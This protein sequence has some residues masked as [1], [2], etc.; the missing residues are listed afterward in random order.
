MTT[1]TIDSD[2]KH[3]LSP[4][5]WAPV[6]LVVLGI[7]FFYDLLFTSKNLY[8]RDILSFHYPLRSV[9]IDAYSRAQFPLWNPFVYF[10]QPLL[11]NPNAMAF[12]P[13]N[14]FHL[15]LPFEYAF[16]L[17]FIVHPLVAGL[18]A[19]FLQRRLGLFP[20]AAFGGSLVYQFSGTVLSFL[21]LYNIVPGIAILPWLGW[22]YLVAVSGRRRLRRISLFAGILAVQVVAM[23]PLVMQCGLWL[24]IGLSIHHCRES[25][26]RR[27]ALKH[28]GIVLV[29]GVSLA[30]LL[31]AV[32]ILPT[33]ELLGHSSRGMGYDP[34]EI[35]RWSMHPMDF[36]NILLPNF[37]GSPYTLN[38]SIYWGEAFHENREGYLV[39][40]F[41]GSGTL[42]LV[43]LSLWSHRR[44]LTILFSTLS[45]VGILFASG[46][47]NP[48]VTWLYEHVG[49]GLGR[50]PSKYFLLSTLCLSVMASLGLEVLLRK[51]QRILRYR[52]AT[53]IIGLVGLVLGAVV[54]G[55]WVVVD[56]APDGVR[57]WIQSSLGSQLIHKKDL[58]TIMNHLIE[59]FRW[60][61]LF[62][63]LSAI[64]VLSAPFWRRGAWVGCLAILLLAAELIPVNIGLTPLISGED[65][66]YVSEV[67]RFLQQRTG[68]LHR[69]IP[70]DSPASL[71]IHELRAPNR[72]AAWYSLFYRRSGQPLYGIA[73]GIQYSLYPSVDDLNT[74]ES[75][76]LHKAFLQLDER[77]IPTFL[78]RLNSQYLL[79]MGEPTDPRVEKIASFD[80]HSDLEL[81]VYQLEGVLPRLYFV[82][83]A[84]YASSAGD[85]L[86]VLKDGEFAHDR[87][88]I[89]QGA[90]VSV[91][92][93]P[94]AGEARIVDYTNERVRCEVSA[95]VPGFVVL[96]DTYYPG[97]TAYLD[98]RPVPMLR[99]NFAFRAIEVPEGTHQIEFRYFP[100]SFFAGLGVTLLAGFATILSLALVSRRGA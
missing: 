76:M 56:H 14:L 49:S 60:T 48:F 94:G 12:Y 45:A 79:T 31:T 15:F 91:R 97:W 89:L 3:R 11:A 2:T 44:N 10:G 33:L 61:G 26:D 4:D 1:A 72:S 43:L 57:G 58:D 7:L 38:R 35:V 9:L 23:E 27:R 37:F 100:W 59:S 80:T 30:M 18:G 92:S 70:L 77:M 95:A 16:K 71:P 99:A 28:I 40:F 46:K 29:A 54:L 75:A 41:L 68:T 51:P 47:Y 24:L 93:R 39:S 87:E 98:G 36:I 90:G 96:L 74:V 52:K 82:S 64:V 62:L 5:L 85:A 25:P 13:T 88:V 81:H 42:L 22:S 63:S 21:N 83:G 78:Q 73:Q 69:V 20:L 67:N 65:F 17:H 86:D 55:A 84:R 8:Y 50:Y 34:S 53:S 19:Y 6:V 32:Q 66:Q